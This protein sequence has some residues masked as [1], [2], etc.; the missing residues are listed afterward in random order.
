MLQCFWFYFRRK[1]DSIN[2]ENESDKT[3][4]ANVDDNVFGADA[5]PQEA[6]VHKDNYPMYQ[7]VSDLPAN[8]SVDSSTDT[9]IPNSEPAV[10]TINGEDDT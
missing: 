4:D 7:V 8:I 6:H 2:L 3:E 5:N 1:F 10:G 9:L